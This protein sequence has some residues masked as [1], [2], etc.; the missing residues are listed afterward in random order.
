VAVFGPR[1]AFEVRQQQVEQGR[2][3]PG[4]G[5]RRQRREEFALRG[6]GGQPLGVAAGVQQEDA[7]AGE[8]VAQRAA[9][10]EQFG[11]VLEDEQRRAAEP[12]RRPPRS[13]TTWTAVVGGS[14]PERRRASSSRR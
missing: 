11:E 6:V 2:D 13:V 9:G 1:Q 12:T 3:L 7:L 8:G 10:G 14:C 4:R 5:G